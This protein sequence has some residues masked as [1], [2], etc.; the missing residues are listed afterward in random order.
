MGSRTPQYLRQTITPES[1]EPS[2]QLTT[3][4]RFSVR[5]A[6]DERAAAQRIQSEGDEE[7][8]RA[9][10]EYTPEAPDLKNFEIDQLIAAKYG[11][12]NA[13]DEVA[14][15]AA[16]LERTNAEIQVKYLQVQANIEERKQREAL[17]A[18]REAYLAKLASDR[19]SDEIQ[20]LAQNRQRELIESIPDGMERRP[21]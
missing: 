9:L 21:S 15:R 1:S 13:K 14:Q 2:T 19:S 6:G 18:Q 5:Q 16:E 7:F 12:E 3:P 8:Q 4:E 17:S 20:R 11:Y 10:G